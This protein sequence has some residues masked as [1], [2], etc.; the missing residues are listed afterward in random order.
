MTFA[1]DLFTGRTVVIPGGTSGIGA[2]TAERLLRS[3]PGSSAAA[4]APPADHAAS[5][6]R[7]GTSTSFSPALSTISSRASIRLM[8]S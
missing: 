6:S 3:V 7:A 1:N 8:C 5:G 2:A 4:L